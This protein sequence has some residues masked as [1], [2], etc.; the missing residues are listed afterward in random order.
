[1]LAYSSGLLL[2]LTAAPV[3]PPAWQP[4]AK[5]QAK[6]DAACVPCFDAIKSRPCGGP[7]VARRSGGLSGGVELWRCYSP[8]T[9]TANKTAYSHGTCYCST[10]SM[11]RAV[12]TA[13]GDP[14]P[15]PPP[16][17]PPPHPPPPPGP[18]A[19]PHVVPLS[20][21]EGGYKTFRIP[22]LLAV[23]N[24]RLLFAE[25]RQG[26]DHGYVDVVLKVSEDCGAS[27]GPLTKVYGESKPGNPVTIGNPS[28]VVDAKHPGHVVLTCCRENKAVL[29]LRSTDSGASWNTKP[30]DIS[31]MVVAPSWHWVATGPPQGIQLDSGRLMMCCDHEPGPIGS[32]IGSHSMFSD[33][34]GATW[35]ISTDA[36][37]HGDE[38][39]IAPTADGGLLMNMRPALKVRQFSRSSDHGSSWSA[40]S[41]AAFP[42]KSSSNGCEG[43]MV[44]LPAPG[45]GLVSSQPH[46]STGRLVFSQ[47]YSTAGRYNM[48]LHVSDD[49]G[50]SWRDALNVDPGSS[51]YSALAALNESS[52]ALAWE[53]LTGGAI[54][55]GVF[56]I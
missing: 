19:L 16:P 35:N 8:E 31:A 45:G 37:A 53:D 42:F 1:M 25:G 26:G 44:A 36:L 51:G 33:D 2:L 17:L 30:V 6:A 40:P 15:T 32:D 29:M 54:R 10:D 21:G 38:C 12:L 22:S 55:F 3:A 11:L 52:V 39:S 9:L 13:C 7:Q 41:T 14:D 27:W 28:P 18:P 34:F 20:P 48:T 50:K 5:C 49:S 4:S 47:P 46:S 43:S 23:G 56:S 24:R